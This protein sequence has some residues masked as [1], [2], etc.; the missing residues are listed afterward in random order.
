MCLRVRVWTH[1]PVPKSGP[2]SLPPPQPYLV[3]WDTL[4]CCGTYGLRS[5]SRKSPPTPTPA[6]T[7]QHWTAILQ[8]S[9]S[10]RSLQTPCP[11][12]SPPAVGCA[13]GKHTRH[14]HTCTHAH[15]QTQRTHMHTCTHT[16]MHMHIHAHM[17]AHMLR[18]ATEKGACSGVRDEAKGGKKAFV[19]RGATLHW[20]TSSPNTRHSYK[21][22][23]L[24][25][26]VSP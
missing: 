3:L 13:P 9:K 2:Q 16:C 11:R 14:A 26:P 4:C 15:M 22:Q 8:G 17:H 25:I 24:C 5:K 7:S 1:L 21:A 10:P 20:V 6:L 12:P 23:N 19:G 18:E